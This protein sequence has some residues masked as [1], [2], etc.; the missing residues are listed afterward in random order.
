M[1]AEWVQARGADQAIR[2]CVRAIKKK[3]AHNLTCYKG[4]SARREGAADFRGSFLSVRDEE[5]GEV[6]VDVGEYSAL[7]DGQIPGVYHVSLYS[8]HGAPF[9]FFSFSILIISAE[10]SVA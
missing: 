10:P 5:Q 4:C 6:R 1:A 3:A 7:G 2:L 8:F 9:A